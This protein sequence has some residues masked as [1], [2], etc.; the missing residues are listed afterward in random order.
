[1][2]NFLPG[3]SEFS[4]GV[5]Y[6]ASHAG[7]YMWRNF[8]AQEVEADFKALHDSGVNTVR[9]F[10]SWEDFQ[11]VHATAICC[12]IFRELTF[13]DGSPLPAEGLRSYGIDPVMMER[14]RIVADLAEKYEL[15]LIVA[16]LTGWMS[17]MM[18][19]PPAL[20]GKNLIEDFQA[21]RVEEMFLRGFIG[22]MKDHPAI[23]AW[24]PGNECNCLSTVSSAD[25]AWNWM[26]MITSTIRLADPTRPIYSGMHGGGLNHPDQA[27]SQMDQKQFFDAVNT[28][29]YP[30][31]TPHCGKSALNTIPAIFHGT[32][33]SLLYAGISGKPAFI[34]EIGAF[35]PNY[36]SDT[37]TEAYLYTTLYSALV[38]DLRSVLWWCGFSFDRCANQPPY[39]WGAMERELGAMHADRTPAGAGRAMK[40]FADE[41]KQLP[42]FS[43]REID[44][45][46]VLTTLPDVWKTAYGSFILSKQAGFEI[47]FCNLN[48]IDALPQS[49]VYIVPSIH[50]YEVMN[51]SKYHLL[52]Q[53]AQNGAAVIFTADSGYLQP[54][55]PYFGCAVDYRTEE[56]ETV[57]FT[58]GGEKFSTYQCIT[59][60]L[61]PVDCEVLAQDDGGNAVIIAKNYGK[62][63]LVYVNAALENNALATDNRLYKVYRFL[64]ETVG[65]RL[66]EKSPETGITRHK[67]ADGRTLKFFINY[68]DKCADGIPGNGVKYE[69]C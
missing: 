58:I 2:S 26:H 54:F 9:I 1:M 33:E 17:G 46:V 4:I 56:P 60:R 47:E 28:H 22:E 21:L 36:L 40:R 59:R 50:Y 55:D 66:P 69:I 14:F 44:V 19:L 25:S 51:I 45:S 32:A 39:R 12:N 27:Y 8:S 6:W 64:A 37:R 63:K 16:L 67:L 53:A 10:P 31:F 30:S 68:S 43:S 35:G 7:T 11:P 23:I 57:T 48:T 52:L 13:P 15:K 41:L 5:N 20:V 24:E 65:I 42:G 18:I 61:A 29:P 62:G 34:E 38:H 3:F 49:K